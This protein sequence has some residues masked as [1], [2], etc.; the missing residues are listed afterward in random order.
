VKFFR[1]GSLG[2]EVLQQGCLVKS[3]ASGRVL[4]KSR[5][6][7]RMPCEVKSF[8]KGFLENSSFGGRKWNLDQF[9]AVA[10]HTKS[11]D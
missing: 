7:G 9:E 6:S 5:S 4:A 10:I 3:R 8:R 2:S 1:K 11:C